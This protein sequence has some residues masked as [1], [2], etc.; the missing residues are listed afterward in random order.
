VSAPLGSATS[1]PSGALARSVDS[2]AL[3]LSV[4]RARELLAGCRDVARVK[5]L[6][7][8]ARA[9]AAYQ[10]TRTA[11]EGAKLD[12]AEIAV[13]AERRLGELLR[14][15]VKHGGGRPEK[16][17]TDGDR[18]GR[19]ADHGLR[20][21]QSERFQRLASIPEPAFERKVAELR[22]QKQ[23][24]AHALLAP[25][26]RARRLERLA[27]QARGNAPLATERRYP[28]ILA[29]PPWRY[30]HSKTESRA[31]ENQ[32][33]TL[34]LD[35]LCALPVARVAL[36]D[37]ALFLWGTSPKLAEAM[38]VIESWGFVYR[39][40]AV[41]VKDKIGMGYFFR[42]R[43]ELL[44]VATRGSPPVPAPDV[45]PDSVIEAPRGAHSEK[46]AVVHELIE[47][48]YPG[49]P[50]LEL[51]ARGKRDGWE[52]WGNEAGRAVENVGTDALAREIG[53]RIVGDR[54]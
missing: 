44:L 10:R 27:E 51:F 29:D 11:S 20:K 50:R 48:M 38:R 46:P 43:H 31:V 15:G 1:P 52:G 36:D 26:E 12:A 47:R 7:D 39:T 3:A 41:W 53:L 4:E 19:L 5:D 24:S 8:K 37:C 30:E 21:Q 54:A 13:W 28:V 42:Q 14:E 25:L 45:R 18:F 16:T 40:C 33:P 35:E 22:A 32:Y 6:R 23:I 2:E 9:I 49:V 17:V 34:S